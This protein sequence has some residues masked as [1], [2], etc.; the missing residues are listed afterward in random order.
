[1]R[2][3]T[4]KLT[5]AFALVGA[6]SMIVFGVVIGQ[7]A[8][9]EFNR[10]LSS[11]D[12]TVLA[13]ALSDYYSTHNGW[14]GVRDTLA[15]TPPL[16][17]YIRSAIVSDSRH[18]IVLGNQQYPMGSV[19]PAA[20]VAA[21]VPIQVQGQTVGFLY[22]VPFSSGVVPVRPAPSQESFYVRILQAAALSA[23]AG[24][25]TALILSILLA[26]QLTRPV[27][28]LTAATQAMAAGQLHQQVKV[29]SHDEIGELARSFNTMS[30]DLTRASQTRKQMTADLA[31]DLRTP[32][33][34]L[35][36]YTEGL[37][38]GRLQGSLKLYEVMYSEVEHLQHLVEDLR[39]LSL[40]DA[41][42]IR[43]N[44]R[45]VDPSAVVER[46][47]LAYFDQAERR[48]VTLR[49][50][51]SEKL[52]SIQADTDR[53]AQVMNNLVSNALHY[54]PQGEIVLSAYEKEHSVYLEVR[55]TG[56]GIAPDDLPY[57]FDRFYRTDKSRQRFPDDPGSTGLGLAIAKALVEAHGGTITVQSKMGQGTSFTVRLPAVET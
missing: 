41:G 52:P 22:A 36:G 14:S 35:R 49:V 34:I 24:A 9:V 3:L 45:S 55:D 12:E 20:Q 27:R 43:L 29:R 18:V 42:E 13:N 19:L 21:S 53:L 54:T 7:R 57:V 50:E 28:E 47:A 38:D 40:A 16:S 30:S 8:Q 2:S 56:T 23:A 31:H 6:I 15:S 39:T 10:F 32:L 26:S 1:M 5:L 44:R 51:A 11:R 37:K 46:A 33:T 17:F 4:L 25:V 48:G